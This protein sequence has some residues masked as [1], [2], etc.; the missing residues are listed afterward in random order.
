MQRIHSID[1]LRG[2][3]ALAVLIYHFM[4]WSIGVPSSETVLG[5]LGIYAV[6]LFFIVSG[7]SLYV[8]YSNS[9]WG[10]RDIL[11]F[12]AKRYLRLAPA[13]WLACALMTGLS[14]MTVNNYEIDWNKLTQNILLSFGF[15]NPRNYLMPG[16]WSIA[17]EMTFYA[18][19]PLVML[20]TK[21]RATLVLSA[22]A[23]TFCTY[24]YY[25]FFILT[26]NNTLAAQWGAYIE[27]LNQAFLFVLGIFIAWIS[28]EKNLK[29]TK[30]L[31]T[32]LLA[33]S[34]AFAIY[35]STGGPI[36]I[37]TGLERILYT[38]LCGAICFSAFN[39]DLQ[40]NKALSN[41]LKLFGDLSYTIY[42]LH[43][44]L[45]LY[46]LEI[47]APALGVSTPQGKLYLL[48]AFTLPA[49][50]VASY[51]FYRLVEVPAISLGRLLHKPKS[52]QLAQA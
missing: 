47:L 35:P 12:I 45:A 18:F 52:P 6:S 43:G 8:A 51:A 34:L 37:V 7:M 25:A 28:T 10:K 5:K 39:I 21:R 42:M 2:L 4:S 19:F 9:N 48:M 32:T 11:V 22:M 49:V 13:F 26:T 29:S 1:Y 24:I 33:S 15:S 31:W 27:P 23:L 44:A 20:T 46:S 16:G 36:N 17:C 14:F 40:L 41:T 50:L 38:A 3:M 30:Y